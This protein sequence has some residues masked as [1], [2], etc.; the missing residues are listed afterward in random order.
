M[1]TGQQPHRDLPKEAP[2]VPMH[3]RG[4]SPFDENDKDRGAQEQAARTRRHPEFS[5]GHSQE[6]WPGPLSEPYGLTQDEL[7]LLHSQAVGHRW[8]GWRRL[9]ADEDYYAACSCGWRSTETGSVS[10]M[11]SQVKQHL[12]AV[13]AIRGGR[14][15]ARATPAPARGQSE[16]DASQR[17]MRPGERAGELYAAADRQQER[18]SQALGRSTD[19]VS[20]SEEQ[21]DRLVAALEHAAARIAPEWART[22]ASAQSSGVLQHRLERA[23]ELRNGIVTAAAGLAAIAEEVALVHQGL[24]TRHPG[25]SAEHRRPAGEA[26]K[27]AGQVGLAGPGAAAGQARGG[28]D[29]L[30]LVVS[31]LFEAGLSLQSAAGLPHEVAMQPIGD[32][33]QRLDDTIR[34]I[35]DR[36]FAAR[37]GLSDRAPRDGPG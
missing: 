21:A 24:K 9:T 30:D 6:N 25:G 32:A 13:W 36:V 29:L 14:L 1:M 12:D 10:P 35:R 34:E 23:K 8:H 4:M 3:R 28:Q 27:P 11:L 33:L 19:L 37:D 2:A 5:Q 22:T 7:D 31:R 18:L 20:A 15:P 16:G 17:D 26:S